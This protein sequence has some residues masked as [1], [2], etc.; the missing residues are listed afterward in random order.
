MGVVWCLVGLVWF[1]RFFV[2][3]GG[4]SNSGCGC[5]RSRLG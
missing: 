4:F 2:L 1:G 5:L 3:W